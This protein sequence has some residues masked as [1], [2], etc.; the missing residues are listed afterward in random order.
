[1]HPNT[2]CHWVDTRPTPTTNLSIPLSL[3]AFPLPLR[4]SEKAR[5][6]LYAVYMGETRVLILAQLHLCLRKVHPNVRR[7]PS[8]Q[9]GYCK[10]YPSNARLLGSHMRLSFASFTLQPPLLQTSPSPW[11]AGSSPFLSDL[12]RRQGGGFIPYTRGKL[13]F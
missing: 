4:P 12:R 7:N 9:Y 11:P 10:Q 6:R 3:R 2:R 5:G 13:E 1:M 8:W